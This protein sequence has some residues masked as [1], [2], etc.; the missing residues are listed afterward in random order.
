MRLGTYSLARAVR[1]GSMRFPTF[2]RN[3]EE[4]I[5][6]DARSA[7][8]SKYAANAMLPPASAS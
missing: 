2:N 7:E 5:H 8:L 6:M 3:H 4:I 1:V